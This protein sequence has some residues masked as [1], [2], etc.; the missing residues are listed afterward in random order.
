MAI[1]KLTVECPGATPRAGT[2]ILLDDV[3]ITDIV[4]RLKLNMAV[5]EV[6]VAEVTVLVG[7]V[8]LRG[9]RVSTLVRDKLSG[10]YKDK[11]GTWHEPEDIEVSSPEEEVLDS[12]R[13][14]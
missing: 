6:N 13:G 11:D 8:E 7:P 14:K 1:G 3:D 12:G 2:K 10:F 5:G 9:D 4:T